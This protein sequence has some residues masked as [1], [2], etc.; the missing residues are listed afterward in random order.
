MPFLDQDVN[1]AGRSISARAWVADITAIPTQAGWLYLAAILDVYSRGVF[2]WA[3]DRLR[4]E[5]LVLAALQMALLQR[6]PGPGSLHHTDRGSRY[7]RGAY[8]ALLAQQGIVVSMSRHGNCYDNALMES[9]FGTPKAEY[10]DRHV[11]QTPAEGP[12]VSVRVP[13]CL[14]QSAA[15]PFSP[16]LPCADYL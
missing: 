16:Q 14:L 4:D 2:G 7:T 10:V 11:F 12:D 8:Q 1:R 3:M 15:P 9:F 5:R 6:R 13:R